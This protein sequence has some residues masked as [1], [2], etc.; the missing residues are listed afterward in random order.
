M[1]PT[2]IY[3]LLRRYKRNNPVKAERLAIVFRK[4][5]RMLVILIVLFL[6]RYLV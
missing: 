6:I 4:I 3:L 5:N 2:I 1:I